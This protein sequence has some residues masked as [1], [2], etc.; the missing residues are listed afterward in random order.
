MSKRLH[1]ELAET[2]KDLFSKGQTTLVPKQIAKAHF[3]KR[4]LSKPMI[5]DVRKRLAKVKLILERDFKLATYLV[6]P[7]YF[8]KYIDHMPKTITEAMECMPI[9]KGNKTQGIKLHTDGE[10]DL[11]W[12]MTMKMQMS[13]G[14]GKFRR[15]M[16][17]AADAV[18]SKR[19]G[20]GMGTALLQLAARKCVPH[21]SEA[22]KEMRLALTNGNG[23]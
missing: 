6:G 20:R 5:E 4:G 18:S 2:V 23:K 8:E 22:N 3:Q 21:D 11:I 14:A 15:G 12:Q 9:G 16:E 7:G 1:S 13:S 10:D 17:R 19:I